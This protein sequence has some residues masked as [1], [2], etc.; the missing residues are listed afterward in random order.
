MPRPQSRLRNDNP[1]L[2]KVI[3]RDIR[4]ISH[5]H[6]KAALDGSVADA[7]SSFS[8][9]HQ[10]IF[11]SAFILIS[12][13]RLGEHTERCAHL[14]LHAGLL[15]EPALT[16]AL[17]VPDPNPHKLHVPDHELSVPVD[18]GTDTNPER[19]LTALERL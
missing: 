9:L 17:E 18:P 4:T 7:I 5:L 10:A 8:R 2:E 1:A 13:N 14:D 15:A 12:Q 19:L 11:P 6:A 16:R 3:E